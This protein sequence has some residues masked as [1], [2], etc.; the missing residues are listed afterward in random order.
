MK[1]SEKHLPFIVPERL[2]L[3]LLLFRRVFGRLNR[4]CGDDSDEIPVRS[5]E[6][7]VQTLF[8]VL[9]MDKNTFDAS[10]YDVDSSGTV[11]WTEFV[12]V[13]RSTK[14]QYSV[15]PLDRLYVMLEDPSSCILGRILSI[16]M[17]LVI[18][19]SVISFFLATLPSM[20]TQSCSSCRPVTKPVFNHIEIVCVTVFTF[21][22][23]SRL[24]A[25]AGSKTETNF[26]QVLDIV[27]S[28]RPYR[29][30][31][32]TQRVK[33]FLV[34]PINV[35]DLIS[36]LPFY[37]ELILQTDDHNDHGTVI[38][39]IRIT[40]FAR[41]L[42]LGKYSQAFQLFGRI[43]T[44]S[45]S[46]FW[47]LMFYLFIALS[48]AASLAYFA[49]SGEWDPS[50]GGVGAFIRMSSTGEPEVSPFKSIPHS[51]WWAIATLTTVGY[52][53]IV[54]TTNIGKAIGCCTMVTG[55]LVLA[56]PISVISGNFSE[57]LREMHE[58]RAVFN[59]QKQE[60]HKAVIAALEGMDPHKRG[61]QILVELFDDDGGGHHPNFLGECICEL[62]FGQEYAKVCFA[63]DLRPNNIKGGA[64]SGECGHVNLSCIWEPDYGSE[65]DDEHEGHRGYLTVSIHHVENL[66]RPGWFDLNDNV[67]VV[68]TV[69][70]RSPD[71]HGIV[72]PE[73]FR[74]RSIKRDVTV[75]WE[76]KHEFS[77]D[78]RE[79]A[80]PQ[81]AALHSMSRRLS[82][83]KHLASSADKQS[84]LEKIRLTSPTEDDAM[85]MLRQTQ[86]LLTQVVQS[87]KE[88][89]KRVVRI[90]EVVCERTHTSHRKQTDSSV[91]S[92]LDDP[93]S[94]AAPNRHEQLSVEAVVQVDTTASSL[95]DCQA[96]FTSVIPGSVN[97]LQ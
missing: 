68:M 79:M 31:T 23:V 92:L 53:D 12:S 75:R 24:F 27:T 69:W 28:F 81:S 3:D 66:P 14:I 30:P 41:L 51:F 20:Q 43:L 54:P 25:C 32:V 48:L 49:E 64:K 6:I 90:E 96:L 91:Q 26:E 11:G 34:R 94:E 74:T 88:L 59:K 95:G 83:Q 77:Y 40:R 76:E 60:D 89:L 61:K 62:P 56:M 17:T 84:N 72:A 18:L 2:D 45:L 4:V 38:R 93:K 50:F 7:A 5:F 22:Y 58:E 78:W 52:G 13:W 10:S 63:Q 44:R 9:G 97:L 73:S 71:V 1:L 33:Q 86:E 36:V 65:D 21:D 46:A 80:Q 15:K 39:I 35:V 87:Q 57:V 37:F 16:I 19:F 8:T 67:F 55:V 29:R 47:V 82:V 42:K 85:D 70:P